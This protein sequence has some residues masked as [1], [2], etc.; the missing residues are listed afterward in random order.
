MPA[1][2]VEGSY[3]LEMHSTWE[4]AGARDTGGTRLGRL[5]R[6]RK[7]STVANSATRRVLLAVVAPKGLMRCADLVRGNSGEPG[8]RDGGRLAGPESN[9]QC[10]GLGLGPIAGAQ[11]GGDRLGVARRSVSRCRAKGPGA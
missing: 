7:T 6:R 5:I 10:T 11:A 1:P 9:P 8:P 3:V 4:P 2:G